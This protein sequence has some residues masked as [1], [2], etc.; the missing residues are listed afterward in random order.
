MDKNT[1]EEISAL[2]REGKKNIV[3]V[4]HKNPDGDAVGS[5]LGLCH[6]LNKAG[7]KCRVITPNDYPG[8]LKWMPGDKSV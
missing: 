1:F 7:H 6:I 4:T 8:F 2:L 5:S 3:I